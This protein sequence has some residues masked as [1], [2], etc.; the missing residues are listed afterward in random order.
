MKYATLVLCHPDASASTALP[1]TYKR[2][3]E[4]AA[5]RDR[6]PE[7]IPSD[8]LMLIPIL[9]DGDTGGTKLISFGPVTDQFTTSQFSNAAITKSR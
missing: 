3:H 5:E 8:L 4:G 6:R 9:S 7:F 1:L 2:R